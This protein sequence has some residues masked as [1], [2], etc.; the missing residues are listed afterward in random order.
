MNIKQYLVKGKKQF[1]LSGLTTEPNKKHLDK[2]IAEQ[3]VD[4]N[5]K[6][7]SELQDKL[8]A[9]DKYSILLIFQGMDA[10]GKDGAIKH[11]MSGLNPQGTQVFSFKQPSAEELDHDYLWRINKSLPE[12]G[13]IGIF[14]RSHYE[15]VLVIRVHDLIAKQK[16][17]LEF[18]T[19]DIWQKR[20]RQI[21]DFEKYLYENGT[22]IIKFYL[23]ISKD[24]QKRRFL[25]RLDNPAKNWKFSESDLKERSYWDNYQDCFS[26]A[27]RE[28]STDYSPWY[29]IPADKKWFARYLMSEIITQTME[30][31]D[32]D[33]PKLSEEQLAKLQVYK[34]ALL[35]E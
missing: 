20:F 32:I 14:N 2:K 26:E 28:T 4:V 17:P 35:N 13:R 1:H 31:L 34:D 7:M 27:L 10:S 21:R 18:I 5:R 33:Y 9:H 3:I 11:V 23:H 24:E 30:K 6:K 19:E 16:L 22:I 12:R 25:E 15:E 8:Y 29:V